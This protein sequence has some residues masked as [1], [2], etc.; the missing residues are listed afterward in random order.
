MGHAYRHDL[1]Q[2]KVKMNKVKKLKV[3]KCTICGD[4]VVVKKSINPYKE[5][6]KGQKVYEYLCAVCLDALAQDI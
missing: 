4:K 3:H 1:T 2:K 5:D 6:V